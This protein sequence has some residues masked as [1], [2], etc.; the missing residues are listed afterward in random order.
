[1][2]FYELMVDDGHWQKQKS[3]GIIIC[4]GTGS[5]S[6]H[7][8]VNHISFQAVQEILEVGKNERE[9]EIVSW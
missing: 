1:M 3:S 4:P 9:R 5:T 8:N 2:S 6:W 7:L